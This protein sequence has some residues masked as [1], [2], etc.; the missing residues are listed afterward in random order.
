MHSDHPDARDSNAPESPRRSPAMASAAHSL[1]R[2]AG[3]VRSTKTRNDLLYMPLDE[4][5]LRQ[6]AGRGD[7][8]TVARVLQVKDGCDDPESMVAAARGGHE[9]VIQLLLGIG[10]AQADPEPVSSQPEEFATPM[11]A[12]IGQE[13]IKVLELL[14]NQQGF[15]PTRRLK[16]ET[17]MISSMTF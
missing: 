2:R 16:G 5:T 6:A 9:P 15:D 1:S 3:T 12:A 4:K 11:L 8:E 17:V 10:G 7:E 13:N 14:L